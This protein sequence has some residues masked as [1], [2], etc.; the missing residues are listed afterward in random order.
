[1]EY[2]TMI[3]VSPHNLSIKDNIIE[4]NDLIKH[5]FILLCLFV[6]CIMNVCEMK[7]A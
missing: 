4:V 5:H 7:Y 3:R 6:S 2:R 1:M